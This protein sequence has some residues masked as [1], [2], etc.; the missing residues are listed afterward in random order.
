MES[1]LLNLL[2][3]FFLTK[4]RL[5]ILAKRLLV[6][7]KRRISTNSTPGKALKPKTI[8]SKKRRGST[9]PG[10]KLRDTGLLLKDVTYTITKRG[11]KVGS[12]NKDHPLQKRTS[13]R[14]N[15]RGS[16]NRKISMAEIMQIHS[17]GLGNNPV[18]PP[19]FNNRKKPYPEEVKVIMNF[20]DD[21]A[22]G[23]I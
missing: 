5:E 6:V 15:T 23:K 8:A 12:T 4:R 19:L 13:K 11:I 20:F 1:P 9:S 18:R 2:N 14:R 16:K 3:R 21:L 10:T 17:E 7:A 22:K